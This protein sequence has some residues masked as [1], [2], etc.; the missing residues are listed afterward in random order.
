MLK[1]G[2]ALSQ[3]LASRTPGSGS[4]EKS[5]SFTEGFL[6]SPSGI[7]RLMLKLK[8]GNWNWIVGGGVGGHAINI[9]F[10]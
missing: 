2:E 8:W 3:G 10:H 6:K 9:W 5:P 1:K 4:S 7:N